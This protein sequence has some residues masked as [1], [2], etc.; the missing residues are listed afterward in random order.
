[1]RFQKEPTAGFAH[2]L[3]WW[4]GLRKWPSLYIQFWRWSVSI[5]EPY[6]TSDSD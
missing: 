6:L 3:R 4:G 2:M 1:M 5:N